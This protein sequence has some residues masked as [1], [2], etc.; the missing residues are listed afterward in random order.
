M[1]PDTPSPEAPTLSAL[2]LGPPLPPG[3]PAADNAAAREIQDAA[4]LAWLA[5][6]DLQPAPESIWDSIQ[7]RISPATAAPVSS[8]PRRFL[9][10]PRTAWSAAAAL[11]LGWAA[12]YFLTNSG[13]GPGTPNNLSIAPSQALQT[14]SPRPTLTPSPVRPAT[15]QAPSVDAGLR[16]ELIQ[17]RQ[18]LADATHEPSVPGL[19]RPAILELRSPGA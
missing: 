16:A 19:L 3:S 2:G 11:A 14:P 12:H 1:Q 7:S 17:L 10:N 8:L 13:P 15:V 18:K 5:L 6:S 4:A 9:A